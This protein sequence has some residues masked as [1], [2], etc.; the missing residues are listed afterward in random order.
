MVLLHVVQ[1]HTPVACWQLPRLRHEMIKS[2]LWVLEAKKENLVSS[3]VQLCVCFNDHLQ[4]K[5]SIPYLV[6]V[7]KMMEMMTQR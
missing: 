3:S 6:M 1:L 2:F 4:V 7:V 5:R